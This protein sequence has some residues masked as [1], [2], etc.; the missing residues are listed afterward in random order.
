MTT[1]STRTLALAR[2]VGLLN[3]LANRVLIPLL[4]SSLGDTL[5]RRLAVLDYVGRRSGRPHRLVVGYL[6]EGRSVRI[7]VGMAEHK[8]WWRN[9]ETPHPLTLRLAGI[10]HH[11]FAH[12]VHDGDRTQVI[13]DLEYTEHPEVSP[14]DLA[15]ADRAASKGWRT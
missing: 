14:L 8:T 6:A 5:G 4:E 2:L 1:V 12:V 10:D 9:F 13:A 7:T 15:A 11:V 3:R